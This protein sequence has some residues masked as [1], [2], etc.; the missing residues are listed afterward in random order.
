MIKY[1]FCLAIFFSVAME[2]VYAQFPVSGFVYD[3]ESGEP[4]IGASVFINKSANGVVSDNSGRFYLNV[5]KSDTLV[6]QVSY[7]GY[8]SYKRTL[9]FPIGNQPLIIRLDKT[10][11][12]IGEVTV[13]NRSAASLAPGTMAL[14]AD[15]IRVLPALLGEPD[16]LESLP[17]F[18]RRTTGS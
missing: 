13:T 6:L 5:P 9:K 12:S 10:A 11:Y 15:Q 14:S 3:R 7:V 1:V 2:H 4:L 16:I 8:R 17:A 18:T